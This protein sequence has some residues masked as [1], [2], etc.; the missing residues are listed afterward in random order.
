MDCAEVD[1]LKQD[2]ASKLSS[3]EH[4]MFVT[5]NNNQM[6]DHDK[7]IEATQRDFDEFVD[8]I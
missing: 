6:S 2:L 4:D 3:H 7:K 5:Q 1:L 8:T